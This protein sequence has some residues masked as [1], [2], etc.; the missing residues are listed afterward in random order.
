MFRSYTS[1]NAGIALIDN[2]STFDLIFTIFHTFISTLAQI[3]I[4]IEAFTPIQALILIIV[5]AQA[6]ALYAL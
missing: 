1:Y 5:L 4:L 2:S 3:P 6:S